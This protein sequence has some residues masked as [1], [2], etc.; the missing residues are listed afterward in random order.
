MIDLP[1]DVQAVQLGKAAVLAINTC[2]RARTRLLAVWD[3]LPEE[4]RAKIEALWCDSGRGH[5]DTPCPIFMCLKGQV[6]GG[7][8]GATNWGGFLVRVNGQA[9]ANTNQGYND[10]ID[11]LIAHELAHVF[12]YATEGVRDRGTWSIETQKSEEDAT[13]RIEAFANDTQRRWGFPPL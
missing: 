8:Y 6:H 1:V 11:S 10:G 13:K 2:E 5:T 4:D 7:A 9:I 12:D 3:M